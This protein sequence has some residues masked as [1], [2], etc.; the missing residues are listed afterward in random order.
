[1]RLRSIAILAWVYV[2]I[3]QAAA[4]LGA[5]LPMGARMGA[6]RRP[7]CPIQSPRAAATSTIGGCG[8]LSRVVL[9]GLKGLALKD[10]AFPTKREVEAVMP[11][12]TW[13]RDDKVYVLL[14]FIKPILG[15]RYGPGA[16][17]CCAV[18]CI[19]KIVLKKRQSLTQTPSWHKGQQQ[20]S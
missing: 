10:K 7:T 9:S 8:D 19:E 2:I 17:V 1:M 16:S 3:P 6:A 14:C 12:G 11:E 4:F 5:P 15:N 13:V 18:W 20:C